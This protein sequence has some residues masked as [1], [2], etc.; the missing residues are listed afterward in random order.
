M[1]YNTAPGPAAWSPGEHIKR[2]SDGAPGVIKEVA[3]GGNVWVVWDQ[4]G[5]TTVVKASQVERP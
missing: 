3:P 5:L 2:Y 4:S 1:Q